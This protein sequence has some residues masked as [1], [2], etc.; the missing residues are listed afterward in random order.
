M[1]QTFHWI[2]LFNVYEKSLSRNILSLVH[3]SLY[4]AGALAWS[5]ASCVSLDKDGYEGWWAALDI[6]FCVEANLTRCSQ[7]P[8]RVLLA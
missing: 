6:P 2:Q 8:D 3:G 1:Q 7:E 4:L 5:L